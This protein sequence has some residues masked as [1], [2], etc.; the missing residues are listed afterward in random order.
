MLQLER[1]LFCFQYGFDDSAV[2][3]HAESGS[4]SI[5]TLYPR[6]LPDDEENTYTHLAMLLSDSDTVLPVTGPGAFEVTSIVAGIVND[7]L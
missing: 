4:D 2:L 5:L 6:G 3:L 1:N 7:R